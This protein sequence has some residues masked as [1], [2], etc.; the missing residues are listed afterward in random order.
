[1][2]LG[3]LPDW[4]IKSLCETG[5]ITPFDPS[6]LNPASLDVRLGD[7]ILQEREE[8]SGFIEC[9]IS[10]ATK[11][12]PYRLLPNEFILAQTLEFFNVPENICSQYALKSSLARAGLEHNLAGWIDPG[13][14]SS[15]LT[16]ELKN[17]KRFQHIPLWPG[18]RIG[19]LIFFDMH[20]PPLKSYKITGHYNGDKKVT[21]C[22]RMV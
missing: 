2:T 4:R 12:N 9:D 20:G 7:L 19:Q 3:V 8:E 17:A 11:E 14:N 22:K 21:G 13:F 1:M 18:M 16:L 5:M 10:Q 15:V 6:L